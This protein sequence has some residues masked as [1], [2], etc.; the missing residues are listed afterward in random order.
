[1]GKFVIYGIWTPCCVSPREQQC[2]GLSDL[3]PISMFY[4][5]VQ[6]IFYNHD[7]TAVPS[8]FCSDW[9]SSLFST[10]SELLHFCTESGRCWSPMG[11]HPCRPQPANLLDCGSQF[12]VGVVD[13][14]DFFFKIHL[15]PKKN[16]RSIFDQPHPYFRTKL[17]CNC[18]SVPF[19]FFALR[20]TNV[21]LLI[22]YQEKETH[23]FFSP[24][25]LNSEHGGFIWSS[26]SPPII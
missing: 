22:V 4:S 3:I 18:V 26:I 21:I 17:L 16:I 11:W 24:G 15:N 1:M 25:M 14:R 9:N 23:T 6:P 19:F 8:L 5:L 13:T 12:L 7:P 10:H 2:L 20:C